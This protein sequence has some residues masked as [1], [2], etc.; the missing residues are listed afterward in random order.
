M[1]SLDFE[2]EHERRRRAHRNY[3]VFIGALYALGFYGA[4]GLLLYL[5]IKLGIKFA[6]FGVLMPA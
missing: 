3:L 1:K 5:Y 2:R 6:T 4:C